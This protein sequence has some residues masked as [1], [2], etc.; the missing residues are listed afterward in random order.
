MIT[1]KDLIQELEA[2]IINPDALFKNRSLGFTTFDRHRLHLRNQN[3]LAA[4]NELKK[5]SSNPN[6]YWFTACGLKQELDKIG[7]DFGQPRLSGETDGQYRKR[8]MAILTEQGK[9]ERK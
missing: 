1:S 2:R 4:I 5:E 9:V 8:L 7:E 3:F 6:L